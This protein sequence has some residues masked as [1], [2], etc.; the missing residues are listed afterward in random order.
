MNDEEIVGYMWFI[1]LMLVCLAVITTW[2]AL[3]GI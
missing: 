3:L 2:P 1:I